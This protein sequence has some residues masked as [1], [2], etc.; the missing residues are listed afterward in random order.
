[1]KTY[2]A[3]IVGLTGIAQAPGDGEPAVLGGA[4]PHSHAASYAAV[5]QTEAPEGRIERRAVPRPAMHE[6]LHLIVGRAEAVQRQDGHRI[7]VGKA[8]AGDSS[9]VR[10]VEPIARE[11]LVDEARHP[12]GELEPTGASV[13]FPRPN[14]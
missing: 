8:A 1:M 6:A 4:Q 7:V 2:R 12:G 9:E 14:V 13:G 10:M 5:D 11:L 3:G